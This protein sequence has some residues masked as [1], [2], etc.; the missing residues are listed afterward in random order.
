MD[1]LIF[2]SSKRLYIRL[3]RYGTPE[4]CSEASAQRF[5]YSKAKNIISS[6]PKELKRLHF[7][8]EGVP[9]IVGRITQ[10]DSKIPISSDGERKTKVL[11]HSCYEV[12]ECV[13]QWVGKVETCNFLAQDAQRRKDELVQSLSNVDKKIANITHIVLFE[14]PQNA[15]NGYKRY[16]E[17]KRLVDERSVIK[18]ELMVVSAILE[19]NIQS[20]ASNHI[21][22][23]VEGLK[24][25]KFTMRDTDNREDKDEIQA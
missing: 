18:D 17:W 7:K 14:R 20:L 2:N 11:T 6:L 23:T 5:E 19:S 12:P 10:R 13:I 25:R 9:N 3:N 21:R 4:T 24:T 8:V 15:C 1:Y 22:K 16:R